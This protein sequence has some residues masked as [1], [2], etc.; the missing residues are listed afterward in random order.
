[1]AR[2]DP[3]ILALLECPQ[4]H[5]GVVAAAQCIIARL[6]DQGL[7]QEAVLR[8]S[9][10]GV[11]P[12]NRSSYGI[13]E[14]A[15]H[16]LGENILAIGWSQEKIQQPLCVEE[17]PVSPY[18]EPYNVAVC[19]SSDKLAP[20]APNSVRAGS[21]TNGHTVLL[22]RC[23]LASVRCDKPSLAIDGKMSLAHITASSPSM[24]KAATDGWAWT[25]IRHPVRALYG[26][27]LFEFL[28]DAH[29]VSVQRLE[30][31][32]QVLLKV[33]PPATTPKKQ[34]PPPPPPNEPPVHPPAQ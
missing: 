32:V 29:N 30:T 13:N 22:L 20:V 9:E 1:M 31:E 34:P 23:V 24:S 15:V 18:I 27:R 11:H 25:M 14:E 21:L 17:D 26:D 16:T 5:G 8:P 6:K 4:D 12:A 2:A 10:M 28:S 7:A 33:P 3:Q 19:S